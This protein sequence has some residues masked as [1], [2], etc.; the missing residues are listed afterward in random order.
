MMSRE[1]FSMS[2]SSS[3][4]FVLIPLLLYIIY[5]Q[6]L[7]CIIL[8]IPRYFLAQNCH[9]RQ[10]RSIAY[11]CHSRI[12]HF[13]LYHAISSDKCSLLLRV[14]SM[15]TRYPV[16]LISI[17]LINIMIHTIQHQLNH[18]FLDLDYGEKDYQICKFHACL[19]CERCETWLS[20][21][22]CMFWV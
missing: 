7:E 18:L 12:I 19:N 11:N 15:S 4:A 2:K 8:I 13:C 20:Y 21:M 3:M 22:I 5:F 14:Y 16:F 1:V 6:S 10:K 17:A 9:Y